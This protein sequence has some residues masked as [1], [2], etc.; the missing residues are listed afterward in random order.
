MGKTFIMLGIESSCDETA[1]AIVREDGTV[2]ASHIASQMD[3]HASHGGVVPEIAARAH[4]DSIDIVI[5]AALQDAG[6][7]M[8]D[9]DGVAA[10]G[11]PGLI[12]G[13]VV[14]TVTA[15]AIASAR[16]LPYFAVNHLE[17][18]A[19]SARLVDKVAFP[20]LLL[21]VS[22]GHTQLL[23]VHGPGMYERYGTTMDDAA[24]EAFDKSA[25][26]MGTW[27]SGRA[28]HRKT[29]GAGRC[30]RH[31]VAPSAEGQ[32]ALPLFLFRTED[33]C[34]DAPCWP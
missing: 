33:S 34:R 28:S 12:G 20:Y 6:I 9:I 23:A 13:V 1:A 5:T 4:L 2:M 10:T 16:S 25:K 18:H 19:L 22:G 17:G 32:P 7:G 21:L 24:G 8:D 27:L 29:G 31:S 3:I 15:K 26:I 11:G 30:C 14:G